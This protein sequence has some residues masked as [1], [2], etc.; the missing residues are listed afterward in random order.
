MIDTRGTD[1]SHSLLEAER[2]IVNAQERHDAL[3]RSQAAL[4][5]ELQSLHA[6]LDG[7]VRQLD[8]LGRRRVELGDLHRIT[9]ISPVWGLDRGVP[10]DRY[11]IHAFLDRHRSDIK[12]RV[13]E[14][15][16]PGYTRMFGDGRVTTVDVLDV[17]PA[18]AQATIVADLSRADAVPADT[19]D[20]FVLT[21]TLGVVYDVAG[22][23]RHAVRMLKPGGVLLCTVPASGRISYEEGLD[24]DY[25]RF[26]EASVRRLFSE[27]LPPEGYE[28]TG[29]GNVLAGAAFL[30]GLAVHE[31]TRE[32][33]DAYDPFFP[34]VYTVR[35]VKPASPS[36]SRASAGGTALRSR[37][38]TPTAAVL[39]YHHVGDP[40]HDG[41][42]LCV[43]ANE[44]E[45]QMRHLR[46][47]G[48]EVVPLHQLVANVFAGTLA[49]PAVSLTFDDGYLD[50][51]SHA[52]PILGSFGFP[53]TFFVVGAALD[54]PY[55]FWW[56]AVDRILLSGATLPGR[57]VLTV[58]DHS[59]DL[60]TTSHAERVAAHGAVCERMYPLDHQARVAAVRALVDWSGAPSAGNPARRPM[61]SAEVV[62]LAGRP[63]MHIGAHSQHH[64]QLPR[65]TRAAKVADLRACR[66]RLESLVGRPVTALSYPY[67]YADDDTVEAARAMPGSS[68]PSPLSR[69]R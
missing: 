44:F 33:L 6:E 20:C 49:R 15:K 21:Q 38:A 53:A 4:D 18:N 41:D 45:Q 62:R 65:L 17:N 61:T 46:R 51:C 13:I 39:T 28:I 34:V 26:T 7:V 57:L 36:A 19:F 1:L 29:H 50:A 47:A 66:T 42:R 24:G 63:G 11:Y 22:A 56:D 16:D 8:A 64:E 40:S 25:W 12:G 3:G 43:S 30:Y 10:L 23:L 9:P 60:P 48:Y 54:H 27:V 68:W 69:A 5:L 55:Q 67:G 31:L 35:A 32:E 59:L 2:R 37:A 14:I 52:A 58:A